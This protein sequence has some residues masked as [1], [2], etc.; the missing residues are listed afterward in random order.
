MLSIFVNVVLPVFI[1]AGLGAAL[2]RRFRIPVVPVNQIVLYLLMPCFI[3]TALLP[4]DLRSEEPLRI[5]AF[6]VLLTVAMLVIGAAIARILRLDRVTTSALLMT[7]AFPNLG[8]YGLSIVLLAYGAEDR[9][10]TRLN[11]SHV[12]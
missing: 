7:A 3:F 11:S 2:E 12:K 1:V 10:S 6:A 9:K 4:I 5:G 8:N